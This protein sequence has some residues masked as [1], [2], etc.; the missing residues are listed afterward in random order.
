M[1]IAQLVLGMELYRCRRFIGPANGTLTQ[2]VLVLIL[3]SQAPLSL[4]WSEPVLTAGATIAN[5]IRLRPEERARG[6]LLGIRCQEG[7]FLLAC[8]CTAVGEKALRLCFKI[9]DSYGAQR[10]T[11]KRMRRKLQW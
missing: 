9:T 7:K 11:V 1:H 3:P 2:T 10:K 4:L 8:Q 5:L 6:S